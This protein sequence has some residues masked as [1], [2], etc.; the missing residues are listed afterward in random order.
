MECV[1]RSRSGTFTLVARYV[2]GGPITEGAHGGRRSTQDCR[3]R[4]V[5]LESFS[6]SADPV[7][8]ELTAFIGALN[9]DEQVDLMTL[10]WM[11]RGDGTLAD[12]AEL[13]DLACAEHNRWTARYLLGNPLLG[14]HLEEG[15]AQFGHTCE[16]FAAE[17]MA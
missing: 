10:M 7:R 4:G 6:A 17:H 9:F 13:R 14:D 16:E 11:G 1:R 8:Q 2:C 15:L 5:S 12:W 3:L